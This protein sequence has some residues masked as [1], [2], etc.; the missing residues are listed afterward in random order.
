MWVKMYCDIVELMKV[1][2]CVQPEVATPH[3][4]RNELLE[5]LCEVMTVVRNTEICR[6]G[7]FIAKVPFRQEWWGA[8][9]PL[10]N[11][12]YAI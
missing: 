9:L 3:L 11:G 2:L 12:M 7:G 8:N 1:M 6:K 4:L 5:S 10:C